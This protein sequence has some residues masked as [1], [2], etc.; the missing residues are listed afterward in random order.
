MIKHTL[1]ALCAFLVL[2]QPLMAQNNTNNSTAWRDSNGNTTTTVAGRRLGACEDAYASSRI[3][4]AFTRDI[5]AS[6]GIVYKNIDVA[7]CVYPP[8]QLAFTC[9]ALRSD[10][11]CDD[12]C[13]DYT[14]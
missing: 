11:H 12:K 14:G 6:D 5:C 1:A 10:D 9:S 8:N 13:K 2:A 4:N 3:S 7:R